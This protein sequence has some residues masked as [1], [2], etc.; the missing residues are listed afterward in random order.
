MHSQGF[1]MISTTCPVC[2]GEG[3]VIRKPCGNCDGSGLEHQEDTLQVSIPAGIED[4]STLRLVGRGE[5]A[6]QGGH[7]GNLY[8]ILRVQPDERFERDGANLHT[9]VAVS[10]PQ[11]ALGDTSRSRRWTGRAR[12]RSRRGRSRARRWRCGAGAC[13]ASTGGAG[14]TSSRT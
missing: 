10:F 7:A 3:R 5:A 8:V 9:E 12:S 11:L 13:R 1:L 14:A 2:R 4:G 6:P